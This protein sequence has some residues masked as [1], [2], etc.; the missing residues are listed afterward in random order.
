MRAVIK[1]QITRPRNLGSDIMAWILPVNLLSVEWVS[2]PTP[3]NCVSASS[4]NITTFSSASKTR[5]K[6]LEDHV[7]LAVPLAADALEHQDGH[8]HFAGDGL[9]NEGFP[10]TNRS[11]HRGTGQVP[12]SIGGREIAGVTLVG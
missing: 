10:A 8:I 1:S 11:C 3:P 2:L 9:E 4:T 5:R 6:S 12:F 7:G